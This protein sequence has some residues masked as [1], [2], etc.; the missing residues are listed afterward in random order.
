MLE[1]SEEVF[2][3]AEA[4]II[5]KSGEYHDIPFDFQRD[6]WAKLL[7]RICY[8]EQLKAKYSDGR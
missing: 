3:N 2:K 5:S 4:Q 6:A 1:K 7:K 8:W